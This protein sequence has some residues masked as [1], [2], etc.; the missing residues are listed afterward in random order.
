MDFSTENLFKYHGQYDKVVTLSFK[1]DSY[2][3]K[4]YGQFLTGIFQYTRDERLTL[5]SI[6]SNDEYEK[7]HGLVRLKELLDDVCDEQKEELLRKGIDTN[8]ITEVFSANITVPKNEFKETDG[9]T[10]PSPIIIETDLSDYDYDPIAMGMYK[11]KDSNG[12]KLT[13]YEECEK[14]GIELSHTVK[15][16]EEIKDEGYIDQESGKVKPDILTHILHSRKRRKV[17]TPDEEKE[18]QELEIKDLSYKIILLR[19]TLLEYIPKK[20]IATDE[21]IS[22]LQHIIPK[23]GS[24]HIKRL[25]HNKIPVWIDLER[26]L[27]IYFHHVKEVQIGSN[28]EKSTFKY[29]FSEIDRLMDTVISSMQ[30]EIQK[31]FEENPDR[32]FKRHGKMSFYF[33]GDY[34][35]I[36]IEPNGRLMTFYKVK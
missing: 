8:D 28:K 1:P 33:K 24:F 10:L 36:H 11:S 17:L 27:H 26:Y 5:E 18:F 15:S 3:A 25:T 9:R 23:V 4:N 2:S 20:E 35:V 13:P 19:K 31:H 14:I 16:I 29:D 32:P 6:I 12:Y 7:H 21:T 34:Y 22:I 30:D